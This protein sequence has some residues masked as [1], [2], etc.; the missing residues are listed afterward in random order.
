MTPH[1]LAMNKAKIALMTRPDSV[2]F[3]TVFFNLTREWSTEVPQLGIDGTTIKFN[4]E[5]FL[6]LD[7]D[8]RVSTMVHQAMHIAYMHPMRVGGRDIKKY[9]AAADYV[10]NLQLKD[11]GFKIPNN[12]LCDEKF[13]GKSVEEVYNLMED[14][15][16]PPNYQPDFTPE[17]APSPSGGDSDGGDNPGNHAAREK[18]QQQED[19]I[20][21]ILMNAT[22]QS[23]M[24]GEKAGSVPGDIDIHMEKFLNPKLPWDQILRKYLKAIDKTD[25]SF[26]KPNR[27][28]APEH[29][30]PG[31]QGEAMIDLVMAID[32]SGSTSDQDVQNCMNEVN[33]IFKKL[34]P[35]KIRLLPFDTVIR[36]EITVRNVNELSRVT[37]TGRGGTL[38][39]PVLNWTNEKKPEVMIIFSDGGFS[40]SNVRTDI[41]VIW[42][43]YDDK[44][45]TAPFG[46]VIHYESKNGNHSH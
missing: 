20:N 4:P 46:K 2:F 17:G 10:I 6:S 39:E 34:K 31:L 13:R 23:Q 26:K 42:L 7:R 14:D 29:I 24:A 37:F 12:W 16:T 21:E 38:I 32:V 27:R 11:R 5:Y 8:V 40:F 22:A 19:K 35:K 15:D 45:F 28:Y 30:L 44:S 1:D 18:A 33:G 43:I 41:P 36:D 3:S 9:C 25:Y